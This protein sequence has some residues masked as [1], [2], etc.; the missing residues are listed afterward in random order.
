MT[1]TTQDVKFISNSQNDVFRI[2]IFILTGH[3]IY[4]S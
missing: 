3:K 4:A 1:L 2:V